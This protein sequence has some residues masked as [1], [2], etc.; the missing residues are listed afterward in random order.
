MVKIKCADRRNRCKQSVECPRIEFGGQ[1]Y[2]Y[3]QADFVSVMIV[4]VDAV[5]PPA[6]P[7]VQRWFFAP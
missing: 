3:R 7:I 2:P 6:V 5:E 4:R 1:R